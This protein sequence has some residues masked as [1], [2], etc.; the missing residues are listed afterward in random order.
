MPTAQTPAWKVWKT[1]ELGTR[2]K[3][4]AHF[5]MAFEKMSMRIGSDALQ[6]I[7]KSHYRVATQPEK[8]DLIVVSIADMGLERQ[9]RLQQVLEMAPTI[10]LELCPPEVGPLLRLQLWEQPYNQRLL[11]GME[12]ILGTVF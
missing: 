3:S 2:L 9:V 1:I 4:L 5:L 7:S 8:I 10:G 6:M 12:P 11:I